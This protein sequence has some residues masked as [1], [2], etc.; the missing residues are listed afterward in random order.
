MVYFTSQFILISVFAG[1]TLYIPMTRNSGVRFAPQPVA[2]RFSCSLSATDPLPPFAEDQFGDHRFSHLPRLSDSTQR[3]DRRVHSPRTVRFRS[4]ATQ[5][6]SEQVIHGRRH[7]L[8]PG[9][10]PGS[11]SC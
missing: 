3:P 2:Q 10:L 1:S 6:H 7:L 4:C 8:R 11:Q 5:Y 9:I